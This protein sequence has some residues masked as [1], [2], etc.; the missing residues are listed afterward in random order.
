MLKNI[1]FLVI[2]LLCITNPIDAQVSSDS[3]SLNHS[4]NYTIDNSPK[5]GLALSG[6]AAH[7]L[8]HIGVIK[9]LEELDIPVDFVTGTSMGSIVGGLLAMG[10]NANEMIEIA[11]GIEWQ[12][13]LGN[14]TNLNDVA[15]LEKFYHE[16]FP[17]LF[18]LED[19]ELFLPSGILGGQK[20]DMKLSRIFYPTLAIDN[21]DDLVIPFRCVAVDI[22][23]GEVLTLDSGYLGQAIRAS[24]AIPMV[25]SPVEIDGRLL[26]DGGLIRNFPVE[27]NRE[28]GA[29]IVIGVYVGSQ[30]ESKENLRS[31]LE[32]LIQ[33]TQMMGLIDSDRQKELCDVLVQPEVKGFPSL[34]FENYEA[35]IDAGYQAARQQKDILLKLKTKLNNRS[36][37]NKE[38]KI[39]IPSRMYVS[40]VTAPKTEAPLSDI[41][42]NRC[43]LKSGSYIELDDVDRGLS[44]IYGTKNFENLNYIFT[45]DENRDTKLEINA[46]PVRKTEIGANFN[47]FA[48]TNSAIILYG[49]VRNK[50]GEPSRLTLLGRLSDN[51]GFKADY[52][53]RFGHHRRLFFRSTHT[54]DRFEQAIILAKNNRR[55]ISFK[56]RETGIG[57]GYET[58]NFLKVEAGLSYAAQ[59]NK[60]PLEAVEES[61]LYK[62]DQWKIRTAASY[63]TMD[64]PSYPNKGLYALVRIDFDFNITGQS[65]NPNRMT[66]ITEENSI[67]SVFGSAQYAYPVKDEL[68][69]LSSVY[70]F[71]RTDRNVFNNLS[72]GGTEQSR[73]NHAPFIGWEEGELFFNAALI[74]RQELRISPYKKLYLSAIANIAYG[75]YHTDLI[76]FGQGGLSEEFGNLTAGI[77][78]KLAYG[79]PIGPVD[80]DLGINNQGGSNAVFGLGYRFIF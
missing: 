18:T 41:L 35:L 20:L 66:Q 59:S 33:S 64:K 7:G 76:Q 54:F 43:G 65:I 26:V 78:V 10:Y 49:I 30:K 50:V 67:L 36:N 52:F 42:L 58:D 38:N 11:K 46:D 8:A 77:G 6:G 63:N 72:A 5:V 69:S 73:I 17:I 2:P 61:T 62:Q 39:D 22:S 56:N 9:Y 23:T 45:Q 48:S 37:K 34:G 75:S 40:K 1:Y 74:A 55:L 44:Q 57:L 19:K 12:E 47:R 14:E 28:M 60:N 31:S 16:K 71:F 27:E 70:V 4:N 68:T 21:F 53:L 79:S 80:L 25:F 51:P 13:I 29:D 3:S 15:P 32:I 24:M